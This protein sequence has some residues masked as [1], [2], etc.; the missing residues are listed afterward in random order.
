MLTF[1]NGKGIWCLFVLMSL[2][3]TTHSQD[4]ANERQLIWEDDFEVNGAPDPSKWSF[5]GRGAPDW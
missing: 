3:F 5:A 1:K 2:S 4:I